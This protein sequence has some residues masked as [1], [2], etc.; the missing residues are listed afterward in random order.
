MAGTGTKNT[1]GNWGD[2]VFMAKVTPVLGSYSTSHDYRYSIHPTINGG[3]KLQADSKG[4]Q[5]ISFSLDVT[6]ILLA[7]K[8][9]SKIQ[10][11]I[12]I[13]GSG[14]P[15]TD[16]GIEMIDNRLFTDIDALVTSLTDVAAE[17]G[18]QPLFVGDVYKGEFV[19]NK[20]GEDT[21]HYP[22]GMTKRA[23][24]RLEFLKDIE[25]ELK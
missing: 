6:Q 23:R 19:L 25:G 14:L 10:K 1:W 16:A 24:I 20:I 9:Y 18:S 7:R 2:V 3:D 5:R 22:D 12:T 15:G 17:F 4:L 11:A 13:A 21:Q 8:E